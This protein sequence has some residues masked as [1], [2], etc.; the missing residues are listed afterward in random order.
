MRVGSIE[1]GLR[2]LQLLDS[3]LNGDDA[4]AGDDSHQD[5]ISLGRVFIIGGAEIYATA[6]K[7]DCCERILWTKMEKEWKGDVWFPIEK[8]TGEE[9]RGEWKRKSDEELDEWCGE[10]GVGQRKEMGGLAFRVEMWERERRGDEAMPDS[11]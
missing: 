6:L 10:E 2:R 7:M 9:Q 8:E 1:E 3:T 5:Q 11:G 4:S